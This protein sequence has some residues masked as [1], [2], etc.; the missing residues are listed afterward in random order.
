MHTLHASIVQENLYHI[1][2]H[3]LFPDLSDSSKIPELHPRL[4][5]SWVYI[6]LPTSLPPPCHRL[7]KR[8]CRRTTG[9]PTSPPPQNSSLSFQSLPATPLAPFP[10]HSSH[11]RY[12]QRTNSHSR[13]GRLGAYSQH[14]PTNCDHPYRK[15]TNPSHSSRLGSIIAEDM[16]TVSPAR[17]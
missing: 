3:A 14:P 13:P 8:S 12:S 7:Q 17:F 2:T 11:P 4:V 6:F 10:S 9:V 5:L 1:T 15:H 16:S